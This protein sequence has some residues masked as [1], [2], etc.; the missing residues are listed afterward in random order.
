MLV[1]LRY[2]MLREEKKG[3]AEAAIAPTQQVEPE[4]RAEEQ[5]ATL[6]GAL[7][8]EAGHPVPDAQ[9]TLTHAGGSEESVSQVDGSFSFAGLRAG[10][11]TL[12]AEAPGFQPSTWEVAVMPTLTGVLTHTLIAGSATGSLRCLVRSFGSE[13][14]RAQIVVRDLAGKRVASGTT[15]KSGLLEIPLASGQYRVAIDATGYQ[16]RRS[17]VQVSPNEVAILNVDLRE[18]P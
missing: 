15:D 12:H 14:L 13:P 4:A 17:N 6:H 8:D 1:G 7:R 3:A 10:T 5:L 18:R 9:V 2:S 16:G 11:V